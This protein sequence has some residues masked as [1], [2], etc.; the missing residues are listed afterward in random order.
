MQ[1]RLNVDRLAQVMSAILSEKHGVTVTIKV[2]PI[3][4]SEQDRSSE[5][6]EASA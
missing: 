4:T 3:R 5:R 1:N 2:E 6:L